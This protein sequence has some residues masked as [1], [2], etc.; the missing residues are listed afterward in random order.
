MPQAERCKLGDALIIKAREQKIYM[1]IMP[2]LTPEEKKMRKR[3]C[4]RNYQ[5]KKRQE[6]RTND[7]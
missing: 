5:T 2:L 3:E 7:P 6:G 4:W 1:G